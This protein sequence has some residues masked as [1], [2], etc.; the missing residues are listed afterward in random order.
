MLLQA[1]GDIVGSTGVVGF[2][3]EAV[4][5][6]GMEKSLVAHLHDV[7]AKCTAQ[8][9]DL[10]VSQ[11]FQ[12]GDGKFHSFIIVHADIGNPRVGFDI[13]VIE[14][15]RRFAGLKIQHPRVMQ[16]KTESKGTN[17]IML[18]HEHVIVDGTLK[19]FVNRDNLHFESGRFCHLPKSGDDLV[20]E[21]MRL[22]IVQVFHKN[23][24][25]FGCIFLSALSGISHFNSSFQNRFSQCFADVRGTV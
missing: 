15:S 3:L 6:H 20:A 25:L 13:V 2:G 7:G 14:N 4:L 17:I 10:F 5:P 23:T 19:L 11:T 12:M 1:L 16:G 21:L 8:I 18:Q 24:H 9:S 22:F